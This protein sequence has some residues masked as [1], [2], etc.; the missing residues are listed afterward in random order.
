MF[1]KLGDYIIPVDKILYIKTVGA[2]CTV[3]LCDSI[4]NEVINIAMVP[5]IELQMALDKLF[6][7]RNDLYNY[8]RNDVTYR[9]EEK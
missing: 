1:I 5:E 4:S 9:K 8:V 6:L 2:G 7:R 3:V